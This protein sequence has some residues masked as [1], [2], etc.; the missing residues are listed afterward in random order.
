MQDWP[1]WP[2]WLYYMILCRRVRNTIH[3]N[4]SFRSSD[5]LLLLF[6]DDRFYYRW[7]KVSKRIEATHRYENFVYYK[8]L[9]RD[10]S[11]ID[12]GLKWSEFETWTTGVLIFDSGLWENG[13][14]INNRESMTRFGYWK[15]GYRTFSHGLKL[16]CLNIQG[17]ITER[18]WHFYFF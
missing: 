2:C 8:W 11:L 5:L 12:L 3:H 14:I 18:T 6:D 16:N 13:R 1:C 4:I 9:R 17:P 15:T 10:W 7:E